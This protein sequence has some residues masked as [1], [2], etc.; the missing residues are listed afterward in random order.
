[1]NDTPSFRPIPAPPALLDLVSRKGALVVRQARH[2]RRVH[3]TRTLAADL[4]LALFCAV[5]LA[6]CAHIVG[7]LP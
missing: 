5:H 4:G 6:W 1:M 2:H 7:L 3:R